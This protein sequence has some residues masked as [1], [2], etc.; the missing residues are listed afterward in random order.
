M[1]SRHQRQKLRTLW[2]AVAILLLGCTVRLAVHDYFGLDGDDVYSM[3]VSRNDPAT[4]IN[5]LLALRLDIHPPLHYLLLKGWISVA[6]DGLLALRTMNMLLDLLTSAM[7]IRLV[8]RLFS[9]QAGLIAGVLW[10][11]APALIWSDY[12]IRMYTLLALCI[13]GSLWCLFEAAL[14]SRNSS[15]FNVIPPLSPALSPTQAE[16]HSS[17]GKGAIHGQYTTTNNHK[18]RF[19]MRKPLSSPSPFAERGSPLRSD[20]GWANR[21]ASDPKGRG[22]VKWLIASAAFALAGLYTHS[23]G[24]VA[25]IALVAATLTIGVIGLIRWRGV[26]VAITCYVAAIVLALPYLGPIWNYYRSGTKLGAQYSFYAFGS[27]LDIPG[28][29]LAV[30]LVHRLTTPEI[31]ILAMVPLFILLSVLLWLH[32]G[33]R[34]VPLL[35]I[36]WIV[37]GAMTALAFGPHIYKT[38]Y[39]APFVPIMLAV[40]SGLIIMISRRLLRTLALLALVGLFV[41]GTFNDLDHTA[42]D[43]PFAATQFIEQ[44]ERPGDMVLVA[45][46]WAAEFFKY[47]YHGSAHVVGVFQGVTPSVDLDSILPFVT[48]GY[49]GVWLVRFQVPALDPNNLLDKWF[50]DH[51]VIGTKVYPMNIPVSY[52]DLAPQMEMLPPYVRPLDARF[53]DVAALRGVYLPVQNGPATDKRL[54]PPS[55]WVQVVLYWETLKSGAD[56]RPRVRFTDSYGQ[57]YG[58][59]ETAGRDALLLN[60]HPVVSWKAGQ[61]W[62]ALYD[63][64]LNPDTPPGIYNIEV[65]VLDSATG[66]PLPA[67]GADAGASWVIAGH[68]TVQ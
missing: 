1:I 23:I 25:I 29:L 13:T 5:G 26:L 19:N 14:L 7:L 62:E 11:F 15:G 4:L 39:L 31:L 57:V 42:R 21:A 17:G 61:I 55:N 27:P 64:N 68:F 12:L 16:A 18:G 40:L 36:F 66:A 24:I 50:S 30:L 33:K 38:F 52:Y 3:L 34:I 28:T 46:D 9:R 35:L 53:G 10:V 43:D 60:R 37:V 32:Y 6:G 45:P 20:T 41:Q 63:L 49:R 56:F 58:G 8:S 51:A 44:H 48:N 59:E 2:F 65:T 54:H 47:H 22:E 67:S